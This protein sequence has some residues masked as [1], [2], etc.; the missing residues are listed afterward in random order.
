MPRKI[1]L[2]LLIAAVSVGVVVAHA[3]ATHADN[4]AL[5]PPGT[6]VSFLVLQGTAVSGG[7]EV[8]TYIGHSS[9]SAQAFGSCANDAS[10]YPIQPGVVTHPGGGRAVL[11][12]L[13]TVSQTAPVP[14][15]TRL[16]A[17]AGP[18]SCL[19]NGVN[20]D[21]WSGVVQ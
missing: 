7:D 18:V 17:L 20:Y 3:P 19:G 13:V 15:G 14:D 6:T 1:L 5:L 4:A 10:F 9:G 16:G 2:A 8:V 12:S 11:A 21:K